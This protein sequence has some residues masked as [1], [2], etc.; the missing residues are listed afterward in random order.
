MP[1]YQNRRRY[2]EYDA[3]VNRLPSGLFFTAARVEHKEPPANIT[4]NDVKQKK[5]INH[6]KINYR[7]FVVP[8]HNS[9]KIG[10]EI[11]LPLLEVSI[12]VEVV[13][14]IAWSKLTQ[15]FT[16]RSKQPIKEATYCMPLY[17]NSTVTSFVCTIGADKVLKGTVKPKEKAKAEFKEAVAKQQVAA[18]LEEHTPEVF[19]TTVGNIPAETTIKVEISYITE[20]KAD[21]GGDGVLVTIPTSVAPRYG[22]IPGTMRD[23]AAKSLAVPEKKG[24]QIKIQVSSPV[25]ITKI[26]S[27]THPVSVEMGSHGTRVTKDIRDFS[28]KQAPQGFDPKKAAATLS[29]RKACLGKDFVLL[30]HANDGQLLASRAISEPHPNIPD[31]SALMVSINLRDLYTPN[32]VAPKTASEIIFVADRSGSMDD[33]IEALKTAMKFFL[34]SLPNNCIFNICSFGSTYELMWP[35]SQPYNQETLDEA[36]DYISNHFSADMG[37]TDIQRALRHVVKRSEVSMNTEIITLTDGEIWDAPSLFQFIEETRSSWPNQ[38]TRFF[39]LGIGEAVSHHLVA[40]IGRFGGGLSE[41][42]ATDSTGDWMQRVIGMLRAALTPSSWTVDV[43]LD[44]VSISV[45][46]SEEKRCIQ[47]PH[48]IPDFHAFSRFSVYFLLN[49]EFKGEVVKIKATSVYSGET[50]TAEIPIEKS[51]IGKKWVHQLAAKAVLSDLESGRS[52]IHDKSKNTTDVKAKAEVDEL[53]KIE[54]EKIGIEWN[55]SSKWTSFIVVDEKSLQEKLS[56]WYQA[57]HS[58]LADLTRP[59]FEPSYQEHAYQGAF[60]QSPAAPSLLSNAD[61]PT[62]DHYSNSYGMRG[63]PDLASQHQNPN[64]FSKATPFVQSTEWLRSFTREEYGQS[65]ESSSTFS[66]EGPHTSGGNTQNAPHGDVQYEFVRKKERKRDSGLITFKPGGKRGASKQSLESQDRP[67]YPPPSLDTHAVSS[68]NPDSRQGPSMRDTSEP[69]SDTEGSPV[70][71]SYDAPDSADG[72]D[73]DIYGRSSSSHP[74]EAA[75]YSHWG[76]PREICSTAIGTANFPVIPGDSLRNPAIA[77]PP[78]STEDPPLQ[79]DSDSDEWGGPDASNWEATDIYGRSSYPR[80]LEAAEPHTYEAELRSYAIRHGLGA[81]LSVECSAP[82]TNQHEQRSGDESDSATISRSHHLSHSP[83]RPDA[84][85][86][87]W[88]SPEPP[89]PDSRSR[90]PSPSPPPPQPS[91]IPSWHP[92]DT[93]VRSRSSSASP[94]PPRP[95]SR[96]V[97]NPSSSAPHRV[98]SRSRPGRRRRHSRSPSPDRSPLRLG[99]GAAALSV[100]A[101]RIQRSEPQTNQHEQRTGDASNSHI[102]PRSLSRRRS[103]S[104]SRRLS[105]SPSRPDASIEKG[106]TPEPAITNS[107]SSRRSPRRSL[108]GAVL[109]AAG[110]RSARSGP[111]ISDYEERSGDESDSDIRPR[112]RS[113]PPPQPN[114]TTYAYARQQFCIGTRSRSPSPPPAA[115]TTDSAPPSRRPSGHRRRRRYRRGLSHSPA[116]SASPVPSRSP[117]PPP[118]PQPLTLTDLLTAQHALGY[119]SLPRDLR[120]RL[121]EN[122]KDGAWLALEALLAPLAGSRGKWLMKRALVLDTVMVV[123]F[124]EGVWGGEEGLWGFV[125]QKARGWVAGVVGEGEAVWEG[126]RGLFVGGGGE[127]RDEIDDG[128][129]D[130]TGVVVDGVK[131]ITLAGAEGRGT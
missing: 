114:P 69:S 131:G 18:L 37:G 19:E 17:D 127:T 103:R 24:L 89:T 10:K 101:S 90:S 85:I 62:T 16:N 124:V 27:R 55:I 23:N 52:W 81:P 130:E 60:R 74:L 68:N 116:P 94:P 119:F 4:H 88:S 110:L 54:G 42:V 21:L 79:S 126:G 35:K 53:A 75:S 113:P 50:F 95:R 104:R 1:Y 28:K 44:G 38:N 96:V 76:Q 58:D 43:T 84:P 39:C 8:K 106:S 56:R 70:P 83:S 77:H 78:S 121:Q 41:V 102:R 36:L 3:E 92:M 115:I 12:E 31:R 49:K 61:T 91:D 5:V 122:Y 6:E 34:K 25:A 22:A 120:M 80:P 73:G 2:E 72:S 93:N 29:D 67:S 30:I 98:R 112:S 97:H 109:S 118:Q 20:L 108:G 111:Q 46:E 82:R 48:Q 107:L 15:T 32:V 9:T 87:K 11:Y 100:A 33:S 40:G 129:D 99:L 63:T 51:N 13:A 45:E 117:S 86:E 65:L 47:A 7:D 125:V 66:A 26:E 128:I 64:K 123:V 71:T 59:R 14:T 105:R 57:G